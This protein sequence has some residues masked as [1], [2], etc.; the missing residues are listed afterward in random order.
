M[1]F[2]FV[3]LPG[4]KVRKN[5][6]NPGIPEMSTCDS[7]QHDGINYSN[8][9]NTM[10]NLLKYIIEFFEM[11]VVKIRIHIALLVASISE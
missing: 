5:P 10:Y 8:H 4:K 2:G 6:E 7:K 3:K 9:L 11:V 1:S